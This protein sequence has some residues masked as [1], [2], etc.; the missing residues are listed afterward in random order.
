METSEIVL[1]LTAIILLLSGFLFMYKIPLCFA[2]KEKAALPSIAII[3]PARNEESNISFLLDSIMRQGFKVNELIVVNDGSTDKTKE[4]SLEKGALVLDSEALPNDWLG[5]PWAC[6]QGANYAK[7]DVFIFL[8]ADV[9][10]ELDG[11]QKIVDTYSHFSNNFKEEIILSVAPFHKVKKFY[12]D[13]SAIFNLIMLGS[14]NAFTPFPKKKVSGLFGQSL[15]LSRKAYFSVDGHKEVKN[16]ILEN[17]YLAKIFSEKGMKLICLG[18]KKAISF[19]MYPNGLLELINGWSKAYA[20]G[21]TQT[22]FSTLLNIILWISGG[23]LI[24]ILFVSSI[25]VQK[26]VVLWLALYFSFAVQLF[27]F[28]RKIGTFKI[29]SSVFYPMHLIFFCLIFIRSF[30]LKAFN[31]KINWKMREV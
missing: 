16:R 27:Y 14:M 17:M 15:I 3:I 18:G 8:D 28:L 10:F 7:S 19:R 1:S 13:F 31:K 11:L 12:E 21:A 22:V 24:S 26:N 23:F 6:Y 4:I 2:K 5:K 29:V 9:W 20:S 25:I 30:Y